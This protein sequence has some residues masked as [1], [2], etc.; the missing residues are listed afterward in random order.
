MLKFDELVKQALLEAVDENITIK[1]YI[2]RL[3]ETIS[4][5]R[6]ALGSKTSEQL[7][8]E[9]VT[10]A[11]GLH[12]SRG[13]TTRESLIEYSAFL[14]IIDFLATNVYL[15][16]ALKDRAANVIFTAV[17]KT[18]EEFKKGMPVVGEQTKF[19]A[20]LNALTAPTSYVISNADIK[21]AITA[22]KSL[23]GM[24]YQS[25]TPLN[26]VIDAVK[27]IGGYNIKEVTDILQYPRKYENPASI[28]LNELKAVR[29]ISEALYFFYIGR[30]KTPDYLSVIKTIIP[31]LQNQSDE[32]IEN[33][34]DNSIGTQSP[35]NRKLQE[36]YVQFLN[37]NS[38]ILVQLVAG[39]SFSLLVSNILQE[40]VPASSWKPSAQQQNQTQQQ[41]NS[42]SQEQPQ[43]T[44]EPQPKP[45]KPTNTP[46]IR[47]ISDF[48]RPGYSGD[49]NVARAY[50]VFYNY[51]TKGTTPSGWQKAGKVLGGFIKGLEDIG[52]AL[53]R[54]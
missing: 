8:N 32:Q 24:K 19:L 28:K 4:D 7:F 36:D 25:K 12:T 44:Q 42:D 48:N 47:T 14:P 6:Q 29:D 2:V 16:A 17:N 15:Q 53:E 21:K 35:Q 5:Y 40:D 46:F 30:I 3:I 49:Q 51:L 20:Q 31:E 23:A 38:K 22:K 33:V 39:E 52:S 43:T 1:N 34:I 45:L 41:T 54:F 50:Q 9:L 37:G 26:G 18:I 27:E 13:Y 10:Q 11:T